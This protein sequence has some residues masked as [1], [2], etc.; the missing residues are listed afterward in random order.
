MVE[1]KADVDVKC[2]GVGSSS[3]GDDGLGSFIKEKKEGEKAD[4]KCCFNSGFG[5]FQVLDR[6]FGC[7]VD[8][9]EDGVK[10]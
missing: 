6:G 5:Y 4:K 2:E 7:W 10:E 9:S 8:G 3:V 1:F